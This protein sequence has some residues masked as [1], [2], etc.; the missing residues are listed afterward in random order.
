MQHYNT[1]KICI[2][3]FVSDSLLFGQLFWLGPVKEKN[4]IAIIR[5]SGQLGGIESVVVKV[6]S[7]KSP[8]IDQQVFILFINIFL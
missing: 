1:G 7:R 3:L 8:K 5:L 4:I 6:L 2:I